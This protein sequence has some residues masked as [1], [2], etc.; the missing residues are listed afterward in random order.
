MSYTSKGDV[1]MN[2]KPLLKRLDEVEQRRNPISPIF[3][4][5]LGPDEYE[6]SGK[7][8]TKAQLDAW[9]EQRLPNSVYVFAW[10]RPYTN[11]E[12]ARIRANQQ[13]R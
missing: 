8:M 7:R 11:D 12:V 6:V 5:K 9:C 10:V 2:L 3:G 13:S 4:W 1:L